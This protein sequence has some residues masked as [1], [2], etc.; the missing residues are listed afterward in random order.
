M[1]ILKYLFLLLLLSFVAATIFVATQKGDFSVTRSKVINS[2]KATV[3]NY[4]NDYKNWEDFSS[5]AAEDGQM[6]QSFSPN[7]IG[8]GAA[9]SWEG[10]E[11]SGDVKTIFVKANDSIA[12]QMNYNGTTSE[13]FW[14]FK[15]TIGGTKVTWKTKGN[16]SFA[17]KI[18]TTFSGGAESVFG[19]IYE[20]SLVNLDKILDYETNTY[21]VKVDGVVKK[22]ATFYVKQS[23][24][25]KLVDVTKNSRIIFEKLMVFC[26]QNDI[27]LNGKP[28]VI[29]HSY[30][31][32][33]ET[34]KL[35]FCVPTKNELTATTGNDISSGKLDSFE[36]VKTTLIGDYSHLQK[37]LDK[38]T[39]YFKTNKLIADSRISHIEIHT[40]G[41]SEIKNPS[42]WNTTIYY[43]IKPKV[44]A[45][46]TSKPAVTT[47]P[48]VAPEVPKEE[49]P[50]SEF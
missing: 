41:K 49:N 7:S 32:L 31:V 34:A 46:K 16:L 39:D 30:D 27:E 17:L 43:P 3:F 15:D 20:K 48:V 23:F 10:K 5:W 50:T 26:Q 8:N 45:V 28:F 42:K 13:V 1:Q 9:Y 47:I 29:Y 25:S 6:K 36:A 40:I 35:S 11:N 22:L 14:H 21:S 24:T 12:Q 38:T 18:A 4:V 2:P 33:N 44:V 19:K 37:A